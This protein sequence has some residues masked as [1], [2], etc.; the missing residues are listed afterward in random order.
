MA[1]PQWHQL[2][3]SQFLTLWQTHL[4]NGRVDERLRKGKGQDRVEAFV[5]DDDGLV[6]WIDGEIPDFRQDI[7]SG[8][9]P[10]RCVSVIIDAP[11]AEKALRLIRAL[12]VVRIFNGLPGRTELTSAGDEHASS[13][14]HHWSVRSGRT[15][16]R[17]AGDDAKWFRVTAGGTGEDTKTSPAACEQEIMIRINGD[18]IATDTNV[19]SLEDPYG[20]NISLRRPIKDID[21]SAVRPSHRNENFVVDGIGVKLIGINESGLQTLNDANWRFLS[22]RT[23]AERH[24]RVGKR[25]RHDNLIVRSVVND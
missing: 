24:N 25:I 22:G 10:R 23:P 20:R 15:A 8:G 14:N 21:D 18:A 11:D 19:R 12:K 1:P 2:R 13:G 9:P 3:S 7:V 16:L 4:P 17:P 6:L 5:G